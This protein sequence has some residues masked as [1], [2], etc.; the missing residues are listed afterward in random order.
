MLSRKESFT[1]IFKEH[2]QNVEN[3]VEK[4]DLIMGSIAK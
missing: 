2:E 4:I 3:I 1:E